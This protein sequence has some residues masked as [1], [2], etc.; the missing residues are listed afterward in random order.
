VQDPV[1][2]CE[3][4]DVPRRFVAQWRL[5]GRCGRGNGGLDEQG[6]DG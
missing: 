1:L 4:P 5:T 2:E 6:H 3:A